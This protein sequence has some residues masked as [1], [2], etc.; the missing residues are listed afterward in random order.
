MPRRD[1]YHHGDLRRALIEAA[2]ELVT[3][4]GPRGFTLTEV[5]KRAGVSVAAPYRHF[6]DKSH[7]LAAVATVSFDQ[8]HAALIEPAHTGEGPSLLIELG[9]R[10]VRWALDNAA[11]YQVM[12]GIDI[13]RGEHP[14]LI[15]AADRAFAVLLHAARPIAVTSRP[16]LDDAHNLAGA[17]WALGHGIVSLHIGGDLRHAR[18]RTPANELGAAA[19]AALLAG[20][21][22]PRPHRTPRTSPTNHTSATS[23][24]ASPTPTRKK[25]TASARATSTKD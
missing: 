23:P 7:L 3:D 15:E 1:T 20:L 22:P 24:P 13:E 19:T 6:T 25:P 12:F 10:Y 9:Q 4:R 2:L 17:L 11:A 18:I 14:E 21:A 8:F 5:A 16:P